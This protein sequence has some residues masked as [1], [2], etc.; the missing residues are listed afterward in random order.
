MKKRLVILVCMLAVS[1]QAA[2]WRPTER[3]LH[4][5]RLVESAEGLLTW[6]DNGNSLGDFQL[7]EAAWLD[8]SAWRK[9]HG[10]PTYQYET[11]VWN[12]AASRE[13]AADY[14]AIL[15]RALHKRLN[16]TPN[17]GE[18]YA[19][20]NMGLASFAQCQYKLARVNPTTAK[21]CQQVNAIAGGR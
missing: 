5:V 15:H 6:G 14:L 4:A 9:A 17:P 20:Y 19:A 8:V 13:Y 18:L 3:L 16:R 1:A 10:L 7:S 21:K 11:H 2:T 12:R